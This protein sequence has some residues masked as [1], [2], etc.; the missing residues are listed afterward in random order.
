M[1]V[2]IALKTMKLNNIENDIS[3][4]PIHENQVFISS[5][6]KNTETNYRMLH[7]G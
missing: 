1:R 3:G 5:G 6:W 4:N 2:I 7:T